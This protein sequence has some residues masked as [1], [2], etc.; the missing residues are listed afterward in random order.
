MIVVRVDQIGNDSDCGARSVQDNSKIIGI[1]RKVIGIVDHSWKRTELIEYC[2][3][4]LNI[5]WLRLILHRF[6]LKVS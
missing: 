6:N 5:V 1:V 3:A 2:V 4:T